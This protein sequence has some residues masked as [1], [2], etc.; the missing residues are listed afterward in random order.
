[1]NKTELIDRVAEKAGVSKSTAGTMVEAFLATVEET[2][3]CG[4]RVSIPGFGIF[5]TREIPPH[6]G[7]NPATGESIDVPG[8]RVARFKPGAGLKRSLNT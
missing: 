3:E 6:A 4:D 1:M 7:R 5:T 2:L 8:R